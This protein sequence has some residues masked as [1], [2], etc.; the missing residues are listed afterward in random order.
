MK[1]LLL[2]LILSFFT[3]T[4]FG[5]ACD[6]GWYTLTFEGTFEPNCLNIDTVSN[7][8]NIW[9]IGNPQKTLFTNS[10]STP[11][12]IV[13]DLINPYPTN[14]TSVF[15]IKNVAT[16]GG[17]EWPHTAILSGQYFV[18]S[19]TLTDYGKIEFSPDN[20][21]TWIDMLNDTVLID[22]INNWYWQ[23]WDNSEKPTLTGNSNG[24]Q[25]F[26]VS[27]AE[28]G[29]AFGIDYLDTV[30]YRF[31][32]IS[33]STQTGKDGL[34]FDDL[35]FEDW[36]EGVDE[37][38]NNNLISIYPNPASDRLV[39]QRTKSSDK[40]TIQIINYSGQV[41]V[42]NQNFVGETVDT[43]LLTNGIYLLRY[44]D[45]KSFAIKKFVINH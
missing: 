36:V 42:D 28:L 37:F 32:F 7:P 6:D 2:L 33:D 34:M 5:Q 1:Q 13:T 16:G 39:I 25:Y 26:Y 3:A 31:T 12:A 22:T 10:F 27:F 18:N 15:I 20:G 19:D 43:Q 17:F 23:W 9:Q 38:Q 44:S 35:H 29:F 4:S 40:S 41:I 45:S 14:D 30:L 24:W 11:N 8:N 21:T